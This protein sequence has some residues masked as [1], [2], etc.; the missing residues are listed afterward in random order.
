M[1]NR[2]GVD[3]SKH[4]I[5]EFCQRHYIKKIAVFGSALRGEMGPDSDVDLLVEF[6]EKHVPGF[7]RLYEIEEEM[8]GICATIPT[9]PTLQ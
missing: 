4:E 9:C 5:A 1:I 2:L 3:V 7:F 8:A 6:K